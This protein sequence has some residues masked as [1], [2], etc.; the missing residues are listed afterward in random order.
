MH[1]VRSCMKCLHPRN[2]KKVI[3]QLSYGKAADRDEIHMEVK[4]TLRNS[5]IFFNVRMQAE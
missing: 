4:N 1:T 2:Y 5:L 3:E